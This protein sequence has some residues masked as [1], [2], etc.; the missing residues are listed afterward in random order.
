MFAL[1]TP[2]NTETYDRLFHHILEAVPEWNPKKV[3]ADFEAP[4]ISAV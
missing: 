4:A 3:N 2:Q 1:L